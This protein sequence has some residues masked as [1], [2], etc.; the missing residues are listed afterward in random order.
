MRVMLGGDLV[1]SS[2]GVGL[3]EPVD[4][5]QVLRIR[6]AVFNERILDDC[7]SR[8]IS[9]ATC[10]RRRK[11]QWMLGLFARRKTPDE[12]CEVDWKATCV[13]KGVRF[14]TGGLAA[15]ISVA[16]VRGNEVV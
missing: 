16:N 2:I 10:S 7:Q 14:G 13:S 6:G 3:K 12:S 11:S 15:K 9:S 1:P 8:R 5:Q 4:E